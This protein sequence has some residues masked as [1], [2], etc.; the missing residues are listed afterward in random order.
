[1]AD[2]YYLK[3]DGVGWVK[4][5]TSTTTNNFDLG[6]RA[7][8]TG[9]LEFTLIGEQGNFDNFMVLRRNNTLNG[10]MDGI[11]FTINVTDDTD[12][13]VYYLLERRPDG[14][15]R[16]YEN[17][18]FTSVANVGSRTFV[19]SPQ[20][21][22]INNVIRIGRL[23]KIDYINYNDR[24]A[25]YSYDSTIDGASGNAVFTDQTTNGNDGVFVNLTNAAW[26]LYDDGSSSG[27]EYSLTLNQGIYSITGQIINLL[28]ERAISLDQGNYDLTG[29]PVSLLTERAISLDQ[30]IY[31][32]TGQPVSLLANRSLSLDQGNYDLTGQPLTLSSP[33]TSSDDPVPDL[34]PTFRWKLNGNT[35]DAVEGYNAEASAG[36]AY[37]DSI[38][39]SLPDDQSAFFDSGNSEINVTNDA[40]INSTRVKGSMSMWFTADSLPTNNRARAVYEQGGSV[41][42]ITMIQEGS[43]LLFLVGESS[44]SQGFIRHA[45]NANQTYH[46]FYSFDFS[47]DRMNFWIDGVSIGE[48]QPNV[49]NELAA[50]GGDISIGG[51]AD[52]R[53]SNGNRNFD[54]FEGK[55]QDIVYWSEIELTG[56]EAFDINAWGRQS[57][58]TTYM[59]SFDQGNYDVTGQQLNLSIERSIL[60]DQGSYDVT[61]QP[62]SLLANRSLSLNEG[63]YDVTGQP[64]SL[65][66]NRSLPL[67]QGSYDVTGQTVSLLANRS[68]PLNQGSYDVTGQPVSILTERAISLEQGSYSTTGSTFSFDYAQ[69]STYNFLLNVGTYSIT[70]NELSLLSER[71]M[72][73]NQGNYSTTGN[74]VGLI[75]ERA[76]SFD[77]GTYDTTGQPVN[78]LADRSIVFDQGTYDVTGQPVSLLA[79]RSLSLDQGNYDRTGQPI[80]LLTQRA[81]SLDQGNYD[82]TGQPVNLLADRVL[83][84]QQGS[85]SVTGRSITFSYIETNAYDLVLG[86]GTYSTVGSDFTFDYV[87]PNQYNITLASGSYSTVG[88][89]LSLL[90][91]RMLAISP[92]SYSTVGD[93]VSLLVDRM[94]N[95]STGLYSVT[96]NDIPLLTNRMLA[97]SPGSYTTEGSPVSALLHRQLTMN[98]GV[99]TTIG[100][101]VSIDYSEFSGFEIGSY[102]ISFVQ[103]P[104]KAYYDDSLVNTTYKQTNIKVNYYGWL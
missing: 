98:T 68:L 43:D 79:N 12:V 53:D 60:F 94:L 35:D 63:S 16:L 36:T 72:T 97:M 95:M 19:A 29:Q 56:T 59:F 41:N 27:T 93:D 78:L 23:D 81:M 82:L 42:W 20:I 28:T 13:N 10:R 61:G 83:D 1:M 34:S 31:D 91:N 40:R 47:L 46:V 104:V 58:I 18:V 64:V 102:S 57:D 90:T 15:L 101:S 50:H 73:L 88:D 24:T 86:Q 9:R 26:V 7:S 89:D 8:N 103:T 96:G 92:G 3:F 49:G 87:V 70:G 38:I 5:P 39:P 55:I 33:G 54:P 25:D 14:T 48:E 65:L 17:G 45:I 74:D 32:I 52:I 77:Q 75:T 84:L 22:N 2:A 99:Y 62:V 69:T 11:D 80:S 85:Y 4:P 30:G 44:N 66:A 71:A 21:G 67:N 76:I 51:S 6:F 100:S 37:T